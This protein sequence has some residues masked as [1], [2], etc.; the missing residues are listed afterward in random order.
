[1]LLGECDIGGILVAIA[2]VFGLIGSIQNAFFREGL[3][4]ES[5]TGGHVIPPQPIPPPPQPVLETGATGALLASLFAL[6]VD[7]CPLAAIL[8]AAALIL[9]ILALLRRPRR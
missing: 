9:L 1:M 3:P 5:G 7:R 8:A 2:F 4:D 6:Q